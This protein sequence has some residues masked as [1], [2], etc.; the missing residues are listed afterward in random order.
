MRVPIIAIAFIIYPLMSFGQFD[1]PFSESNRKVLS[2][3]YDFQLAKTIFVDR[4]T[5]APSIDDAIVQIGYSNEYGESVVYNDLRVQDQR[6]IE[7]VHTPLNRTSIN[8]AISIEYPLGDKVISVGSTFDDGRNYFAI[9]YEYASSFPDRVIEI[10]NGS[11]F[12]YDI[13]PINSDNWV[14]VGNLIRIGGDNDIVLVYSDNDVGESGVITHDFNSDT[15]TAYSI[16]SDG[17]NVFIGGKLN[18]YD[19]YV[20][21]FS[22]SGALQTGFGNNGLLNIESALTS[23]VSPKSIVVSSI[24]GDVLVST[25][26]TNEI[27]L[28]R[29][30]SNTGAIDNSFGNSGL[31]VVSST[32]DTVSFN[33]ID[34]LIQPDNRILVAG[35][36]NTVSGSSRD[37]I[38]T[39]LN[40]DGTLDNSFNGGSPIVSRGIFKSRSLSIAFNPFTGK[41]YLS[42]SVYNRY[43]DGYDYF[44][45]A[46]HPD[47]VA[48]MTFN[49]EIQID[50]LVE[51]SLSNPGE[52]QF[53]PNI[54]DDQATDIAFQGSNILVSGGNGADGIVRLLSSGKIDRTFA[55]YGKA[56]MEAPVRRTGVQSDGRIIASVG[57]D[58]VRLTERGFNDPTFGVSGKAFPRVTAWDTEML[59]TTEDKILIAHNDNVYRIKANGIIDSTFGFNG[60]VEF[61]NYSDARFNSITLHND[62]I[63]LGKSG[64][65]YFEIVRLNQDGTF[66]YTFN[67]D[68]IMRVNPTQYDPDL[69]D[70]YNVHSLYVDDNDFIHVGFT[71]GTE[72]SPIDGELCSVLITSDGSIVESYGQ[73]G[74]E[75]HG[76]VNSYKNGSISLGQYICLEGFSESKVNELGDV[77]GVGYTGIYQSA[78]PYNTFDAWLIECLSCEAIPT[79]TSNNILAEPQIGLNVFPNPTLNFVKV[80]FLSNELKEGKLKVIDINGRELFIRN[81]SSVGEQFHSENIDMSMM[82]TGVYFIELSI[83]GQGSISRMIVKQ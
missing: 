49:S 29:V 39:R 22:S 32:V 25:M 41:V 51:M 53:I 28:R 3:S 7:N 80:E 58:I 73:G 30:D 26:S 35:L 63:Y 21:S 54:L 65:D 69:H 55:S 9:D 59:I 15:E 82:D 70:D 1:S 74:V 77:Y 14:A 38:L 76:E 50:G 31:A 45:K 23:T 5:D 72:G 68:G 44:T 48:D 33:S 27:H 16:T 6:S 20:A 78:Y 71:N 61:P 60:I 79:S 19:Y 56:I 66:D 36:T 34:V 24:D 83:G 4:G 75:I 2:Y 12:G 40:P 11:S 42:S 46:F 81:L 18:A 37:L 8:S 62:K 10:G 13:T 47:G 64:D 57:L 43:K 52:V 67:D 17:V